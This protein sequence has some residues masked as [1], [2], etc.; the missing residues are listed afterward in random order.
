MF[1]EIRHLRSLL[2]IFETGNLARAAERLHVTQ[3]ALSHQIKTLETYFELAL[4]MRNSK[5]LRLTPAGERLV[6]LAQA[7]LPDI[8]AAEH[9]LR[10]VAS[11]EAG[12][13]HIAIECHACFEWLLPVLNIFRRQWPAIEVDI[14]ADLSFEA[15][16]ALHKG[17]ID[18][19][20]GSDPLE[21]EGVV[22][23][24]LFDYESRL[25]SAADH[26]LAHKT[27]IAPRDLATETLITYPV[28]RQRLDVFNRFLQPAGVEPAAVRSSELTA[29][30]LLLVASQRGVAVLPDWVVR[31]AAQQDRLA[32]RPLGPAG[33]HGTLHA[34]VR[35]ADTGRRY[36]QDF[37]SLAQRV[38][39]LPDSG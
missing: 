21:S 24:A 35:R 9:E 2:A 6:R 23:E 19:M 4:F 39:T 28:N 17:E 22:F 5:P 11:G 8:A 34:A 31:E 20:I 29:V 25:V 36:L 18:L 32:S 27:C 16:T 14:R 7:V 13:L 3:S 15:L 12:R 10:R 30:I 37:I 38:H 33:M 26:P 1:L